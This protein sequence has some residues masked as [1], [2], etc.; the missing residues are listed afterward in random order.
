MAQDGATE[1]QSIFPLPK[2]S[3]A[4][5]MSD[6]EAFFHEVTGLELCTFCNAAGWRAK[7]HKALP[8][9]TGF[10]SPVLVRPLVL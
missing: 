5:K 4:V 10:R 2:C 7:W 3:F 9:L 6:Q 1:Q 8:F